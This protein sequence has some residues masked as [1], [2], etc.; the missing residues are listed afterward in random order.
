MIL[1]S[2]IVEPHGIDL[3]F[4]SPVLD[5]PAYTV[6][7]YLYGTMSLPVGCCHRC[8]CSHLVFVFSCLQ[9]L[10]ALRTILLQLILFIS[11]L[12]VVF[13]DSLSSQ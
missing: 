7:E 9:L 11:L 12:T 10:A 5:T 4:C 8:H 6:R 2:L 3:S 13:L 1:K